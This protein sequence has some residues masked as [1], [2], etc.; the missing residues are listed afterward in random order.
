[1]G[2][3]SLDRGSSA[4]WQDS[5]QVNGRDAPRH[6]DEARSN[7]RDRK[8]RR[9]DLSWCTVVDVHRER[10]S[11]ALFTRE[12]P[13]ASKTLSCDIR[14]QVSS[15]SSATT[16]TRDKI[17]RGR[18]S[19][20]DCACR[21]REGLFRGNHHKFSF[22]MSV[23][24]NSRDVAVTSSAVFQGGKKNRYRLVGERRRSCGSKRR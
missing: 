20:L 14:F 22:G 6:G 3:S 17:S 2:Q 13:A 23:G 4:L 21:Q 7:L 9:S 5:K 19:G 18:R 15:R 1:M 11:F 24:G 12:H 10:A 16:Q 8:G